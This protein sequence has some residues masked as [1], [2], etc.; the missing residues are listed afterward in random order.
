MT[1]FVTFYGICKDNMVRE[2]WDSIVTIFQLRLQHLQDACVL[3]NRIF[4]LHVVISIFL[5]HIELILGTFLAFHVSRVHQNTLKMALNVFYIISTDGYHII[6]R[7]ECS[8][9]TISVGNVGELCKNRRFFCIFNPRIF[10][11]NVQGVSRVP[12]TKFW[13]DF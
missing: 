4:I 6:M 10:R 9:C 12:G 5:S 13:V 7:F 1:P 3:F 2:G 11:P 8:N